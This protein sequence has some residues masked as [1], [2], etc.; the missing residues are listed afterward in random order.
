M[1]I[2]D[3][4][5]PVIR[6]TLSIK[7]TSAPAPIVSRQSSSWR[8]FTTMTRFLL[9]RQVTRRSTAHPAMTFSPAHPEPRLSMATAAT[10][11]VHRWT[12]GVP[13]AGI[14]NIFGTTV[15]N[16]VFISGTG[17]TKAWG[18]SGNDVY[19]YA[20][21]DGTIIILE[22]RQQYR[23]AQAVRSSGLTSSNDHPGARPATVMIC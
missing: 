15:G 4:T 22:S 2:F 19:S 3:G 6:L 5:S 7:A 1:L 11:R 21:G 9:R 13:Y 18:N 14:G 20:S 10:R 12:S 23:H 17:T 16:N 8:R